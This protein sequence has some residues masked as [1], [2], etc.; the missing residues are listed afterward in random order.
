MR[1]FPDGIKGEGFYQKE[2]GDYFPDWI[3]RATE[4]KAGGTTTYLLCNDAATLVYIANQACIEPHLWL[5]REDRPEMPDMLVFDLDPPGL[6]FEPVRE[7]AFA[8]REVF[9][10][11]GISIFLKTTGSKGI[12]I[13]LPLD[14]STAFA[15]ARAFAQGV[16]RMLANEN[17]NDFTVEVRKEKRGNRVFL[18]TARNSYAQTAV[19]PY[20]VRALPGAPVATPLDWGELKDPKLNARRYNIKN[21]FAR[22]ARKK[23]PWLNLWTKPYSI[24]DLKRK[25]RLE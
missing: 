3:K 13:V 25:I 21:I 9:A 16:A 5:S 23:D 18:D 24:L 6:D 10:K 19:A 1:R 4:K 20:S 22:L 15:E 2:I 8:F 7:A 11:S 14:R 17:P 12:H